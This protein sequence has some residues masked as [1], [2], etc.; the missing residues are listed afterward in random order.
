MASSGRPSRVGVHEP[1]V[2]RRLELDLAHVDEP[3]RHEVA[4]AEPCIVA[5][6]E[7]RV[8]G[9]DDVAR[10][11]GPG[12]PGMAQEVLER[13]RRS[14]AEAELVVDVVDRDECGLMP[15]RRAQGNE[16]RHLTS[17]NSGWLTIT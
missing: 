15:L 7:R 9:Q 4:K 16:R 2:R 3:G 14:L 6:V 10:R 5:R 8:A 12:R 17:R 1:I 13:L 11:H